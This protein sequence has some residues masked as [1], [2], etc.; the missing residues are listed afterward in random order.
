MTSPFDFQT[1]PLAELFLPAADRPVESLLFSALDSDS[2]SAKETGGQRTS[3]EPAAG[4]ATSHF[5]RRVAAIREEVTAAVRQ[6]FTNELSARL[7]EE[8]RR[9]DRAR[10]EFARDRQRFFTAAESQVVR[11]ALA[12][13]SDVLAREIE[14]GDLHL[15]DAVKAA[16]ARVQSASETTLR[17]PAHEVVPWTAMFERESAGKVAVIADRTLKG[18]DCVLETTVGRVEFGVGLQLAEIERKFARLLQEDVLS[19]AAID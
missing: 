6:D 4:D 7:A 16:L 14:A 1:S 11:L 10:L 17:V 19:A 15:A 9:M 8:H 12:I 5:E 13:A 2:E 18:G 3:A